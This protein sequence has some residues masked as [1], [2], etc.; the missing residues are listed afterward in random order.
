MNDDATLARVARDLADAL[1]AYARGRDAEQKSMVADLQT[2]LC[3]TRRTEL[4]WK[5]VI[6]HVNAAA[7]DG[8]PPTPQVNR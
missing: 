3:A 2:Q 1:I 8:C 5:F 7:A 6:E 4:D